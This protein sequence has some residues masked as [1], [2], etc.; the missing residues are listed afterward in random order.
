MYSVQCNLLNLYI[1]YYYYIFVIYFIFLF[2][3]DPN[4]T[5]LHAKEIY[6]PN[7]NHNTNDI[8]TSPQPRIPLKNQIYILKETPYLIN[9]RMALDQALDRPVTYHNRKRHLLM[10]CCIE[11]LVYP[12][13]LIIV[14]LINL[15]RHLYF[16]KY[17]GTGHWT[18]LYLLQPVAVTLPLL[19]II[20]PVFWIFL[21]CFGMAR[22]KAL[23]QLYQSSSKISVSLLSLILLLLSLFIND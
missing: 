6:N 22:F 2:F 12:I 21:N 3:K 18:E 16:H 9:L 1:I 23:F 20:F 11:Q 5:V 17:A 10:I 7:V 15:L 14:L 13:L 8:F 4:G 19:P